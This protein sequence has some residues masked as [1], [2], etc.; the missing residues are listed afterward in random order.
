M[1]V[2]LCIISCACAMNCVNENII[3]PCGSWYDV[4]FRNFTISPD[5]NIMIS[6][7]T[8]IS[9][10]YKSDNTIEG[11]GVFLSIKGAPFFFLKQDIAVDNVCEEKDLPADTCV[12][13][14]TNGWE[15][16]TFPLE[17]PG[18]PIVFSGTYCGEVSLLDLRGNVLSCAEFNLVIKN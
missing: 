6:Q 16:I 10:Q 8:I 13:P 17:L 15:T 3:Q 7:E 12:I 11:F 2:L 4:Q 18:A 14:A 5:G 1:G 9:F